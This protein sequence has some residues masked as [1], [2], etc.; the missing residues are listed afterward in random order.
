MTSSVRHFTETTFEQGE[1]GSTS[2]ELARSY[3]PSS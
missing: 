3:R 2:V 1:Q